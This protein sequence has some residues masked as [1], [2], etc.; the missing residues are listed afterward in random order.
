MILAASVRQI[1]ALTSLVGLLLPSSIAWVPGTIAV[2]QQ[3]TVLCVASQDVSSAETTTN[4]DE[5]FVVDNSIPYT[6]ARG[7]GSTGG[8]GLPMPKQWVGEVED[9]GNLKRPKVG[10]EMPKG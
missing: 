1:L 7:D 4:D 10:A 8:G 9:I 3:R 5:P 2:Q 6:V